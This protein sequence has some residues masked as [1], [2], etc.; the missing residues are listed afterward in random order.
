MCGAPV[1]L[2]TD[3][4]KHCGP[5][6][7]D[8][9]WGWLPG[10]PVLILLAHSCTQ[11]LLLHGHLLFCPAGSLEDANVCAG[12]SQCLSPSPSRV[13][14]PKPSPPSSPAHSPS[15]APT[16]SGF[17]HR[18]RVQFL[19]ARLPGKDLITVPSLCGGLEAPRPHP[20]EPPP[21]W[22]SVPV[23]PARSWQQPRPWGGCQTAGHSL[24]LEEKH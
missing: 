1:Y 12:L 19:P 24:S 8:A 14:L 18:G 22:H 2:R 5:G 10:E 11:N 15:Q 7:V 13:C 21:G 17:R 16:F 20:L 23:P 4:G 9:P 3:A 6:A